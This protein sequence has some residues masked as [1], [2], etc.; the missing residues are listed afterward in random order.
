MGD[1]EYEFNRTDTPWQLSG[2]IV[3][4][5]EQVDCGS[6]IPLAG[7]SR[8]L[9]GEDGEYGHYTTRTTSRFLA[10]GFTFIAAFQ[11]APIF[12]RLFS[13]SSG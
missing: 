11:L 9:L 3:V 13:Q 7:T 10:D 5:S 8:P 6:L 1:V 2:R 4:A 12:K